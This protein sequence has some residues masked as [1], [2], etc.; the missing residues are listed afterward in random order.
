MGLLIP[1]AVEA[2]PKSAEL[3]RNLKNQFGNLGLAAAAYNAGPKRVEDWLAGRGS[4]PRIV[5]GHTA[6]EWASE[7]RQ[8]NLALPE[9]V[10]CAQMAKSLATRAAG[11]HQESEGDTVLPQAAWGVQLKGRPRKPLR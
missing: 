11:Q 10:P 4:L 9:P 8:L 2:I 5:T 3:L 1:Y 7:T 6:S